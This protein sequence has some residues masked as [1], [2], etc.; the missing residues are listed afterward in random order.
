MKIVIE[1]VLFENFL[2][3]LMV[4][5]TTSLVSKEETKLCWLASSLGACLTVALPIFR[6][7]IFGCLIV[8]IGQIWLSECLC[9]KFRTLKKF[10]YLFLCYFVSLMV[11][12]GGCFFFEK[13][14]GI[15]ST[16]LVLGIVSATFV[17]INFLARRHKHKQSV[18]NFCFDVEIEIDKKKTKCKGFLDSGNMLFDPVSARPVSLV[19]FKIFS[20]MFDEIEL[21]DILLKT[22]RLRKLKFAHYINFETLNNDSKI[23]IFQVDKMIVNGKNLGKTM[24]GLSLKNFDSAFGTDII[25]HNNC[26]A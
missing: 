23:L 18:D 15:E 26:C 24:L 11:Y 20:A 8:E 10:V 14:F 22:K 21:S 12:G 25:L 13:L 5:K 17:V 4:L 9:F 3:N 2:I 19:N 16:L 1:Y 6:L 7:S